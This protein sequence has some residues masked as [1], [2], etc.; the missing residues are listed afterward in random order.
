ME[1]G[2][3]WQYGSIPSNNT[4]FKNIPFCNALIQIN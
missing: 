2:P 3:D 4:I 1:A